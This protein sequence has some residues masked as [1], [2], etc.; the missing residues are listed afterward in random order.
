MSAQL[1]QKAWQIAEDDRRLS[2]VDLVV[3]LKWAWKSIDGATP[4]EIKYRTVA[5]ETGRSRNAVKAS[6]R[7]LVEFG[8]LRDVS[9]KVVAGHMFQTAEK[10]SVIDPPA[11]KQTGQPVTPPGSVSDPQRGQSV[12]PIKKKKEKR[13]ASACARAV[14][15]AELSEFQRSR[16]RDGKSVVVDGVLLA[17]GTVEH[18]AAKQD[19]GEPKA[20]AKPQKAKSQRSG[21]VERCQ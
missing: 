15:V 16:L 21:E 3:L 8:Y 18:E 7:R 17:P 2:A 6:V 4:Y 20:K 13:R 19:L 12:T 5:R 1:M 14:N 11:E 10:G 9:V